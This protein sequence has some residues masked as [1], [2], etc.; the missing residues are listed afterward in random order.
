MARLTQRLIDLTLA[1][2]GRVQTL[3][4]FIG[5]VDGANVT[6]LDVRDRRWI[7]SDDS[8]LWHCHI[9]VYRKFAGD[10]AAM[11]AVA[12]AILGGGFRSSTHHH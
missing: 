9:S 5:T 4:E 12:A 1:G 11:D 6:G 8:H 10:W 7:T 3:R 2:D